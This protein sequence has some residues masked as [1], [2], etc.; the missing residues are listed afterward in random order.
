MTRRAPAPF[1]GRVRRIRSTWAPQSATRGL[2]C[3]GRVRLG[4]SWPRVSCTAVRVVADLLCA[5][6][7][8]DAP[9]SVDYDSDD[10]APSDDDLDEDNPVRARPRRPCS[11]LG[12]RP[13][14]SGCLE[15]AGHQPTPPWPVGPLAPTRG[16]GAAAMAWLGG[17]AVGCAGL[18][19][20]DALEARP[21][22]PENQANAAGCRRHASHARLWACCSARA[23]HAA[24]LARRR[25]LFPVLLLTVRSFPLAAARQGAACCRQGRCEQSCGPHRQRA[26][27]YHPGLG[28]GCQGKGEAG[29]PGHRRRGHRRRKVQGAPCRRRVSARAPLVGGAMR[30]PTSAERLFPW[31]ALTCFPAR[32]AGVYRLVPEE[33]ALRGR[34]VPARQVRRPRVAGCAAALTTRR[35]VAPAVQV[36]PVL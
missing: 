10:D 7:G 19:V 33:R 14:C 18:A 30:P 2:H 35:A 25:S 28:L 11:A 9:A 23:R 29:L 22:T 4:A 1:P 8:G 3:S 32:R 26:L 20:L 16:G 24:P 5:A 34:R 13:F 6:V 21:G 27:L 15:Q 31:L 36:E 17:I 12:R